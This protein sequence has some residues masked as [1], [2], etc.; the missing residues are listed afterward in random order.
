MPT[1]QDPPTAS[2]FPKQ[3]QPTME[4][5]PE[6][7]YSLSLSPSPSDSP[8]AALHISLVNAAAFVCA[9]KLKGSVQFSL[10][11]HP[12]D[13]KLHAASTEPAPPQDLS[14]IPPEYHDFA[15]V[16]SKAKAMELPLHCDFNLKID[17]EEGASPPLGTI[18]SLSPS[19][20]EAL[21]T[22]L[23]EHLSYRFIRQSKSAHGAP[24]LFVKKK[25]GSLCLCV[26]YCGLNKISKKD[27]Y[28]LPLISDLLDSPSKGKVY[29]KIN[30]HHAYHLICIA[31][32][33]EWKTAFCT[34]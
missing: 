16:F 10:Q 24:V 21:R 15:D 1:P 18:Y 20:L 17:L 30:L 12:E 7:D 26:N 14:S 19:E 13:A 2:G 9:C 32:G 31:P 22:F 34:R 5:I 6:D 33:D 28:P 4:E 8:R 25:D 29:T 3:S 23:D 11:L 27:Q